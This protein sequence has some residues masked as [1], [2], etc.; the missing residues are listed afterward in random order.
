MTRHEIDKQSIR[1][2]NLPLR[3]IVAKYVEFYDNE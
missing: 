2:L 1:C 3:K